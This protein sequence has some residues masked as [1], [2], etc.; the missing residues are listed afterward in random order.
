MVNAKTTIYCVCFKILT[1]YSRLQSNFQLLK[2][3]IIKIIFVYFE[4]KK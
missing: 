2:Y 4:Y 1:Y 3:T